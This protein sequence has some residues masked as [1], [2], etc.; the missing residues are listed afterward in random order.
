MIGK[1]PSKQVYLIVRTK[2]T[3]GQI[4]GIQEFRYWASRA[5]IRKSRPTP[6]PLQCLQ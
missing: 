5:H 2:V 6:I 3:K 1:N 4:K